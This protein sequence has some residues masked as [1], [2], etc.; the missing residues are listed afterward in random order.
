MYL[1]VYGT[2]LSTEYNHQTIKGSKLIGQGS[3]Y[4]KLFDIGNYP[5]LK[6]GENIIIGELYNI[7]D[8][9]L[10]NC[11]QLEGYNQDDPENSPYIRKSVTVF[12]D[13]KELC[14]HVY[15]CNFGTKHYKEIES[16][17]YKEYMDDKRKK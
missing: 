1:F 17:N 12:L 3:I 6:E 8:L 2:L 9:T 7:D 4:G 13:K 14:A 15:Y 16:G 5:A 11:D 10:K